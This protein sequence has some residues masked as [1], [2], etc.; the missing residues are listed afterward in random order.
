LPARHERC[1]ALRHPLLGWRHAF[2]RLPS[3]PDGPAMHRAFE[4]GCLQCGLHPVDGRMPPYNF[5][6]NELW[7]LVV[8]RA[9]E[10]CEGIS[11]NALGFAGSMFVRERAQIDTVRALGPLAMLAKV[12]VPA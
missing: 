11:I 6:V 8:P 7:M 9:R 1:A 3:A 4:L 10:C 5:L 2:V 12:A